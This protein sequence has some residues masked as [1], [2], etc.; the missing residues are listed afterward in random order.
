MPWGDLAAALL[1]ELADVLMAGS[2]VLALYAAFR[3]GLSVFFRTVGGASGSP[4][5]GG[6][7]Y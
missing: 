4:F 3:I 7:I 1:L 6:R 2:T 5:E